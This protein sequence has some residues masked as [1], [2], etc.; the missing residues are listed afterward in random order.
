[1]ALRRLQAELADLEKNPIENVSVGPF[2]DNILH[3]KGTQSSSQPKLAQDLLRNYTVGSREKGR[4]VMHH[5]KVLAG[6][7]VAESKVAKNETPYKGGLFKIDVV[8]NTDYPFKPPKVKFLTKIYHPNI[9]EEGAICIALLKSD[10]WKPATRLNQV[11]RSL[12]TL[13]EAPNPE[14]PLMTDIA[15]LY[16]SDLPRFLK[17]AKEHTRKFAM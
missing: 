10:Q 7:A 15:E 2:E 8:F 11:L 3:W 4:A 9:D 13:L 6:G 5:D 17:T 12:V 1:M 16:S 14:D